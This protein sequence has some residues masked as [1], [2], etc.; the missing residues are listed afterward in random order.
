M[1]IGFNNTKINESRFT[2][3]ECDCV[4]RC[5]AALL[6]SQVILTDMPDRLRLL[7]K[8]VEDNLYGD[9]RGCATVNE[10]TWGDHADSALVE[11]LPDFGNISFLT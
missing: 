8:N 3:F 7:K 1:K 4:F 5:I 10:L 11:P 2:L 6:G 9:V